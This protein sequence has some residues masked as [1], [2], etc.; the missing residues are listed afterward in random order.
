M[1][2]VLLSCKSVDDARFIKSYIETEL[3]YEVVLSFDPKGIEAALKARNIH[4]LMMQTGNLAAQDIAYARQLRQNG[5]VYPMLMITDAIG[6]TNVEEMSEKHK[7]YFLERPFE[8]KALKG[9]AR[10]LMVSKIVPQQVYRRYRTNLTATLETFISGEKFHT[11]MFNL[12]RGGAYFEAN[13]KPTMQVGDL[14]RLKVHLADMD[15]EHHVHGRIVWQTHK[16]HAA[17]GFGLGVK[18][19]KSTDIYRKLL[20]KM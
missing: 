6:D 7:I 9:L 4:L 15:R 2:R 18:F 14:L 10:K 20:D 16:G 3:P 1:H 17:G 13:K 12:S 8:L 19:M 11:H 5:F